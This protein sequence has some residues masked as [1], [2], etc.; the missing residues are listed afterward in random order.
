ME[1]RRA[2][3]RDAQAIAELSGQLGYAVTVSAVTSR[4]Q[5]LLNRDD[6]VVLVSVTDGRVSGWIHGADQVIIEADQRCEIMGLVVDHGVRRGG[7][8]R[9]LV[10]AVEE[11]A[12]ARGLP[13][14]TVRSAV[15]R[16]ESHPFYAQLGYERVKTQHVYHKHPVTLLR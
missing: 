14:V 11:W 4:L 12:H 15:T 3:L 6:Q 2:T 13:V 8:G 7:L 5:Q 1:I 10:D 9:R 16:V